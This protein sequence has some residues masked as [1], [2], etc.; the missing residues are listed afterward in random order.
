MPVAAIS[1]NVLHDLLDKEPEEGALRPTPFA[2]ADAAF[3]ELAVEVELI[4]RTHGSVLGELRRT[5]S[6]KPIR[7]LV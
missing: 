5:V 1:N 7:K 6:I 4:V 3:G 2:T